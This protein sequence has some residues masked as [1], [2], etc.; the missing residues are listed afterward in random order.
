M[1]LR[2]TILCIGTNGLLWSDFYGS[3]QHIDK[4]D[5][6]A[7]RKNESKFRKK[8][9][10]KIINYLFFLLPAFFFEFLTTGQETVT[11]LEFNVVKIC[12]ARTVGLK[13]LY[14]HLRLLIYGDYRFQLCTFSARLNSFSRYFRGLRPKVHQ[15]CS[16]FLILFFA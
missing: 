15:S 11:P 2:T 4:C 7:R 3:Q 1:R 14:F 16:D 13:A 10:W 6:K 5:F 8:N 12:L 9:R